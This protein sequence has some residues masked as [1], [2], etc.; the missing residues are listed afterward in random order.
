MTP[1]N[2]WKG[3]MVRITRPPRNFWALKA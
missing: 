1:N 3:E 2:V